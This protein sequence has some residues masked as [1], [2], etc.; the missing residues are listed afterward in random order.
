MDNRKRTSITAT[1]WGGSHIEASKAL[2]ARQSNVEIDWRVIAGAINVL[3]IIR[4]GWPN[5]GIDLVAGFDASFQLIADEGWAEP[6]TIEK[7]PNIA[8]IPPQLLMKDRNGNV[9][10]IPR[11]L[12][13]V[14]WF[15]RDDLVPFE[16]TKLDDLLDPRLKGRIC[17]PAMT[18]NLGM[19]L[20]SLALY[21]GGGERNLEPAWDFL[22][23][24]ALS[25]NIGRVG[26][27]GDEVMASISSG[28]TWVAFEACTHATDLSR[29]VSI[30]NLIKMDAATGFRALLFQHG[31]CVLKG[32]K[33]D[34]A[35]SFAN[36]M[37][38]AKNN[39]AF[40]LIAGSV[41]VNSKADIHDSVKAVAFSKEELERYTYVPD[42]GV[43]NA[44]A[45]GYIKR[46]DEEIA[47]L[48]SSNMR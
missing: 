27:S 7:V 1:E 13:S 16:I 24:L 12:M 28:E 47:P 4:A 36:Y 46:W 37:I 34:A 3:P 23:Q 45:A 18:I 2:A 14:F 39:A 10:N 38:E 40:N 8:E 21:K 20:V 6:V 48:L 19:Q 35:F 30:R 41:P 25:G 42:W 22:K 31:W 11:A 17:F 32:A 26:R 44:N 15:C 5:P 29:S 33:S 9:I 43:L